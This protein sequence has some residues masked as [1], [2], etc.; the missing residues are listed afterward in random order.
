MN[1]VE[2]ISKIDLDAEWFGL[3]EYKGK[4]YIPCY[5]R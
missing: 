4:H 1:L 3:R 5:Q 2:I